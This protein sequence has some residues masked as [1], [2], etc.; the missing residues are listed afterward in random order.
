[1]RSAVSICILMK[2]AFVS[3]DVLD[4]GEGLPALTIASHTSPQ[5]DVIV[6]GVI[7]F[8]S[9]IHQLVIFGI[10]S[11]QL[12]DDDLLHLVMLLFLLRHPGLTLQHDN[13][14]LHTAHVT[15][16]CLLSYLIL[17]WPDRLLDLSPIDHIWDIM[18]KW[19]QPS[20]ST[21]NL[22]RAWLAQGHLTPL[23]KK[24]NCFHIQKKNFR[25]TTSLY[26]TTSVM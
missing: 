8:D 18:R 15:M 21:D 6:W 5:E 12:Y 7:S 1:M 4:S 25:K 17:P 23:F 20:G 24:N 2:T 16:N 3:W 13:A 10:V 9:R 22:V 26:A 19:L 11:S 14:R